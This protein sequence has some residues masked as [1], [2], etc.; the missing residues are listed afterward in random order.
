MIIGYKWLVLREIWILLQLRVWRLKIQAPLRVQYSVDCSKFLCVIPGRF[1]QNSGHT[2][3][4]KHVQCSHVL[5]GYIAQFLIF[6]CNMLCK[7]HEGNDASS[8]WGIFVM[9]KERILEQ[10]LWR[11]LLQNDILF[12]TAHKKY[13]LDVTIILLLHF[14]VC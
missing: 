9:I 11:G 13:I 1:A 3:V 5:S 10:C 6:R 8:V 14:H 7:D 4:V 12:D 2:V